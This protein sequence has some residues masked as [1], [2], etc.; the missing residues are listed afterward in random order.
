[1]ALAR[2][3]GLLGLQAYLFSTSGEIALAAGD[4]EAAERSF[5]EGLAV[6]E[7]TNTQERV[8]GLTANLGL[9]AARR[10]ELPLAIHR[11][12]TALA[13]ADALGTRHLAAQVRVW[14][15]PLLPPAEARARLAEARAIAES[16]GRRR[17]LEE[18]ARLENPKSQ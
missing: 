12:S 7:R 10:G 17:L 18:I 15:A 13:Q 9:V 4:L 2:D 11:L 16:G 6:A 14:L 5:L 8:A 1:L 3:H